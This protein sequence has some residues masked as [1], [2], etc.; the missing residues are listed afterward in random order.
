[1]IC[2]IDDHRLP[3]PF[4]E[5]QWLEKS[6]PTPTIDLKRRNYNLLADLPVR[7]EEN[8]YFWQINSG[9]NA[10]KRPKFFFYLHKIVM[11][12]GGLSGGPVLNVPSWTLS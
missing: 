6:L 12:L 2:I 5:R 10:P 7:S 8:Q 11:V 4:D 3:L 9:K 1:M